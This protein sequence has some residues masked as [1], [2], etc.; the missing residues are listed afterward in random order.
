MPTTHDRVGERAKDNRDSW[1]YSDDFA[2]A[3]ADDALPK[4]PY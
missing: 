1:V 2:M 4:Y 3:S